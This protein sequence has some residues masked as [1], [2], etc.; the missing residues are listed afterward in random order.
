MDPQPAYALG[1]G[2]KT[3]GL[4][5]AQHNANAMAIAEA[6][7]GHPA[8]V[9][10]SYPGLA[11]HPDHAIAKAQMTGFGGM[12]TIDLKGGQAAAYR[13]FDRFEVVQRATSLGGVESLAGLPILTSHFGLTDDEL[14][15]AGVTK[16]MVRISVGLED[17]S[18]LIAD[19]RQAIE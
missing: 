5:V 17:A 11:S 4:R 1:R 10:V 13:A 9:S 12:L 16:G 6:L 2:M 3:L 14:A 19:I 15:R 7:E 18:D 8:L